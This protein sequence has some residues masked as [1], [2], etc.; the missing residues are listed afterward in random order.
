MYNEQKSNTLLTEGNSMLSGIMKP[1]VAS[2]SKISRH[3]TWCTHTPLPFFER[4]F[5]L[6]FVSMG[7]RGMGGECSTWPFWSLDQVTPNIVRCEGLIW[8]PNIFHSIGAGFLY[9]SGSVQSSKGKF[10]VLVFSVALKELMT[11]ANRLRRVE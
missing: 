7:G 1:A 10:F 4:Y 6:F 5:I 9:G 8:R 2:H 11:F 3:I